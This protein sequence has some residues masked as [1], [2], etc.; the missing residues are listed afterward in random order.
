MPDADPWAELLEAA[1]DRL[2]R[3]QHDGPCDNEPYGDG[4]CSLHVEASDRRDERLA[5]AVA[6]LS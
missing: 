1:R 2:L 3:G 5:R 6:A 4:A